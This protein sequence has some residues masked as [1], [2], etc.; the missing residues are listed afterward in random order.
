MC[1]CVCAE[2]LCVCEVATHVADRLSAPNKR[3]DRDIKIISHGGGCVVISSYLV[4]AVDQPHWRTSVLTGAPTD[5]QHPAFQPSLLLIFYFPE[6]EFIETRQENKGGDSRF[7]P[8]TFSEKKKG[9]PKPKPNCSDRVPFR[10]L[11]HTLIVQTHCTGIE[12]PEEPR[13]LGRRRSRVA[14]RLSQEH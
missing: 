10:A 11:P 5:T 14:R 1:L 4:G 9:K 8:R 6:M 13:S 2:V 7:G 3:A 12:A